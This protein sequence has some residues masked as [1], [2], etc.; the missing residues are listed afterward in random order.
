MG[1]ILAD[2]PALGLNVSLHRRQGLPGEVDGRPLHVHLVLFGHKDTVEAGV[3]QVGDDIEDRQVRQDALV[4]D[5]VAAV[6]VEV[7]AFPPCYSALS[8]PA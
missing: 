8:R 7:L 2:A 3:R 5:C 4:V 6:L 1:D